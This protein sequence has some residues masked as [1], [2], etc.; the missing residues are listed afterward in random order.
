MREIQGVPDDTSKEARE[1][2]LKK[3]RE[4][5]PEEKLCKTFQLTSFYRALLRDGIRHRYPNACEQEIRARF[6]RST[7]GAELAE[8][9]YPF[10]N[11]NT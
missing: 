2:L 6:A 3:L 7:L 4:M 11:L 10:P 1:L 9:Y 5:T 8:K